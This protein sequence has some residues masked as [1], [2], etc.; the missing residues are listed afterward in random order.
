MWVVCQSFS[1]K[2]PTSSSQ[3]FQR[4]SMLCNSIPICCLASSSQLVHQTVRGFE[5]LIYDQTSSL[6]LDK[7]LK[8]WDQDCWD[9]PEQRQKLVDIIL[10]EL[11]AYQFASPAHQIKIQ[12]L[13]F[14]SFEFE[15]LIKLGPSPTLTGMASRMLK[16]KYEDQDD[17]VT[18]P[19]LFSALLRMVKKLTTNLR[20]KSLSLKQTLLE[21]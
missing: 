15:W 21:Q 17:S 18:H 20:M 3:T 16:A 11:L 1:W 9:A 6:H 5:W 7:V 2:K 10:V 4:K 14:K 19:P 13:L 8:K 12:D